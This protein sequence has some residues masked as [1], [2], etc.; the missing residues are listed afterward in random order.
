MLEKMM[1]EIKVIAD[2]KKIPLP[3]DIV[4]QSLEVASNFPYE[5]KTS[6]QLDYEK[7]KQTEIETFTGYIVKSGKELG[8]ET[9][10]HNEIYSELKN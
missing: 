10:L 7:E 9:P 1:K 4:Q 2:A 8:I 6:M 5:T 3:V